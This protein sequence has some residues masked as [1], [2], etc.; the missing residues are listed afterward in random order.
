MFRDLVT[1]ILFLFQVSTRFRELGWV[2]N[3]STET[4]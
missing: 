4:F 2:N 3:H 1:P